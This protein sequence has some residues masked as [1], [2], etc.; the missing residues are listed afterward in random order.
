MSYERMLGMGTNGESSMAPPPLR[1]QG[2][3]P[4]IPVRCSEPIKIGTSNP[5]SMTIDELDQ[6]SVYLL[7]YRS[8]CYDSTSPDYTYELSEAI[9]ARRSSLLTEKREREEAKR[10]AKRLMK[11]FALSTIPGSLI[12][13]YAGHRTEKGVVLGAAVG[14]WANLVTLSAPFAIIGLI[15][16]G[17]RY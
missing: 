11:W 16:G 4:P 8:R 17:V 12:G 6:E 7:T 5:A 14:A 15:F 2:A 13:A 9:A 3:L 10:S 1:P